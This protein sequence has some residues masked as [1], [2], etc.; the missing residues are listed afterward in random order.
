M[1]EMM[2]FILSAS[3][4]PCFLQRPRSGNH[5][6]RDFMGMCFPAAAVSPT[7]GEG[8]L[9]RSSGVDGWQFRHSRVSRAGLVFR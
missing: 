4:F 2:R 3:S 8:R 1:V 6:P 5:R 7:V 9:I